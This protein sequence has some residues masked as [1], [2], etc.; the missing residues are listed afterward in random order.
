MSLEKILG[1][2]REPSGMGGE[3]LRWEGETS[4][5]S[6]TLLQF[7][8]PFDTVIKAVRGSVRPA[9]LDPGEVSS[10]CPWG[11]SPW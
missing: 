7:N 5:N 3:G 2:Y 4:D 6:R 10:G 9:R 8:T 11:R 1:S